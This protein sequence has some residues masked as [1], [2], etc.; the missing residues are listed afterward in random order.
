MIVSELRDRIIVN[1]VEA[2][3]RVVARVEVRLDVRI[4]VRV[5]IDGF[6]GDMIVGDMIVG[7]TRIRIRIR[8]GEATQ[9]KERQVRIGMSMSMSMRRGRDDDRRIGRMQ[10]E[11]RRRMVVESMQCALQRLVC[12][13]C[14]V[15]VVDVCEGKRFSVAVREVVVIVIVGIVMEIVIVMDSVVMDSVVFGIVIVSSSRGTREDTEEP[16]EHCLFVCL[17][18]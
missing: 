6:V 7:V 3:R 16:V 11:E 10:R 2:R 13:L 1:A 12:V 4:R 14:V 18:E 8:I 15:E 9:S 5:R 17:F